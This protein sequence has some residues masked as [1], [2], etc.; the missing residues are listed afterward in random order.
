VH[1]TA[2]T[3]KPK[4]RPRGQGQEC[5]QRKSVC[6]ARAGRFALHNSERT[7]MKMTMTMR[8]S[9]TR[10]NYQH[11]EITSTTTTTLKEFYEYFPPDDK[12]ADDMI[13][14]DDFPHANFRGP[15]LGT[16]SRTDE[17]LFARLMIG[18]IDV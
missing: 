8:S 4:R 6:S 13:S 14:T 3:K 2:W 18:L 9:T 1:Y 12:T 11:N 7:K 10:R 17:L 15:D 16:F 5:L